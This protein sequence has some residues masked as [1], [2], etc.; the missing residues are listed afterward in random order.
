MAADMTPTQT[1]LLVLAAALA[2]VAAI[3]ATVHWRWL[4]WDVALWIAM[5]VV[6]MAWR[7]LQPALHARA[8]EKRPP[9]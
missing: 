9:R 2:A 3:T 6:F 7:A 5:F 1:I 4:P 8:D